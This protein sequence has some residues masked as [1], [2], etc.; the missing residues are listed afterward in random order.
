[1]ITKE[2]LDIYD[3]KIKFIKSKKGLSA[4]VTIREKKKSK[5][6]KKELEDF[7]SINERELDFF[8]FH[9]RKIAIYYREGNNYNYRDK[10]YLSVPI[11][12][13]QKLEI[14]V[15]NACKKNK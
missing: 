14:L 11:S 8:K 3:A 15:Y 10:D 6:I 9:G 12:L 2:P 13:A 4:K 1:M 7:S 5:A